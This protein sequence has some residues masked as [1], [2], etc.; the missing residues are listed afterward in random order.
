MDCNYIAFKTLPLHSLGE[1]Q[2]AAYMHQ[3]RGHRT[4]QTQDETFRRMQLATCHCHITDPTMDFLNLNFC[5]EFPINMFHFKSRA[6][7]LSVVLLSNES[8]VF[9]LRFA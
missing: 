3:V 7:S 4:Q 9:T 2:P 8:P 5:Y 1:H 6:I